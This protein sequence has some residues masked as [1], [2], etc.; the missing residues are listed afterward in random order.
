MQRSHAGWCLVLVLSLFGCS[1]LHRPDPDPR[2]WRTRAEE[3]DF[4]ATSDYSGVDLP[5]LFYVY[6]FALFPFSPRFMHLLSGILTN[7]FLS[8]LH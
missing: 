8:S 4:A 3:T 5:R 6:N 1:A 2:A 7:Q